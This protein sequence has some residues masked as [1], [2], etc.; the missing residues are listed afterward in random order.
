MCLMNGMAYK[1]YFSY[2]DSDYLK[3]CLLVEW[4]KVPA[5]SFTLV[6]G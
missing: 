4:L 3:V 6:H 1:L 2:G 5:T